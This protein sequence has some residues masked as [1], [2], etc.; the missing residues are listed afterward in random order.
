MSNGF[1]ANNFP[2]EGAFFTLSPTTAAEYAGAYGAGIFVVNT[3]VHIFNELAGR[4]LIS[5][6]PLEFASF[7]VSPLGLAEFSATS[8]IVVY[9]SR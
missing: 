5:I 9:P 1:T 7:I 3:P 8:T 6:D 2:G 4:G